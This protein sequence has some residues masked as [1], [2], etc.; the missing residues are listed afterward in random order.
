MKGSL[1][2]ALAPVFGLLL[3]GKVPES[4]PAWPQWGGPNRNFLV[5]AT[6]LADR[7]PDAGPRVL[8]SR[9]LGTGHSAIVADEGRLF[10]LYRV[11]NGRERKGPWDAEERVIAL[12]VRTGETLW[13]HKYPSSLE[14]FNFGA[15]PHSTPFDR[16]RASLCPRHQQAAP[17]SR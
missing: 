4:A 12:D 17:R 14:D 1:L 3:P 8:W 11:G 16:W 6:G 7:W 15:G 9:P 10:T 5:D 2:V 13:E